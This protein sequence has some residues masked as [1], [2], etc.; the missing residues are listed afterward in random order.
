MWDEDLQGIRL[1]EAVEP[2]P[3]DATPAEEE[4]EEDD[5]GLVEAVAYVAAPPTLYDRL[6][7]AEERIAVLE[8][9][10]DALRAAFGA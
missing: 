5:A 10:F 3:L 6:A 9:R 8:A 1:R 4:E 7:S 2:A